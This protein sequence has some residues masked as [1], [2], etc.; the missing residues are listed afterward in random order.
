MSKKSTNPL[1]NISTSRVIYPVII[2][3]GVVGYMFYREFD[4]DAFSVIDFTWYSALFL[5]AALGMMAI[6]DIGYMIRIRILTS[7]D[8]SWRQ[9]FKII[10]LW[11]FTS[12]ITPSSIGGT[13]VAILFVNKENITL[14]RSSAVVMATS[15]LDELYFL[16]MFPLLFLVVSG[17]QL[18]TIGDPVSGSHSLSFTNEFFYF[19]VIGYGLK[20]VY[21]LIVSYGLF[22]NPRGLKWLLLWIFRLPWLRRWKH[23]AN[24]AG[25]EIISSSSELKTKPLLFWIKAFGA[26]FFSWTARYWVVNVLLLAFFTVHDHFLIFARQLVMWIMML[27]SPTP[28][29]SGFA[30]FVFTRYLS[31]FIP[32]PAIHVAAVAIAMSLIWRL[33]SYYP[34]LIMGVFILPK[35]IKDKFGTDDSNTN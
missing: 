33:V 9:A 15:F 31:E 7:N 1:G 6:R 17:D 26:T 21:T 11:E 22:I 24:N 30:E 5:I 19:A 10:M 12:A 27:V 20:L 13:S 32:V 25:T 8:L 14:G 4:P 23:D 2:G 16:I 29:G 34:Y 28:G 18:F 35:W 3:L